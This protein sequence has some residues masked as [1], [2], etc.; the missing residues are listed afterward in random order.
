[1]ADPDGDYGFHGETVGC[2]VRLE[3]RVEPWLVSVFSHAAFEVKPTAKLLR[4][5][6]E[7]CA[8]ARAV[9]VFYV[10]GS[11]IVRHA[12]LARSVDRVS[13]RY[14]MDGVTT[15]ADQVGQLA[16]PVYGC[17]LPGPPHLDAD[18]A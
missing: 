9:S 3:T 5:L 17:S 2:W 1:V 10:G 14:A 18:R 8:A 16:A 12:L 7:I 11:V 6:D 4:E 15:I 13:L